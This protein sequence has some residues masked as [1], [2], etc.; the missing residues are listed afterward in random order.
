MFISIED[1]ANVMRT[2]DEAMQRLQNLFCEG[3]DPKSSLVDELFED[4]AR[5]ADIET[6]V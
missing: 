3:L 4:R 1:G 2:Y 5:E 6:R